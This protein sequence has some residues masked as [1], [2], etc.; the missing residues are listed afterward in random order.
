M[1]KFEENPKH[2]ALKEL[3]DRYTDDTI[4]DEQVNRV[5]EPILEMIREGRFD[6]RRTHLIDH[7]KIMFSAFLGL[8]AL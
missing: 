7:L 5:L 2:C 4:P 6:K 8:F 3:F 1:E